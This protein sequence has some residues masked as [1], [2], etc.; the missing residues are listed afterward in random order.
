MNNNIRPV[1]DLRN[2]FADVSKAV[3]ETGEPIFL[4]KNG[5]GDM[6]IMSIE[7]YEAMRFE[8]KVYEKLADA[9]REASSTDK[10][11]SSGD[12]RAAMIAAARKN[13][14]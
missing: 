12:V 9:E 7:A 11:F 4:T 10:R 5:Y 13:E 6:V 2:H 8:N 3:H 1:S 14:I